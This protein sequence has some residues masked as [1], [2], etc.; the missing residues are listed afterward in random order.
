MHS[1]KEITMAMKMADIQKMVKETVF[2][3]IKEFYSESGEQFADF[4]IAVPITVE[5]IERWA[6]ISVVCGQ[7]KDTK[8]AKAFDPFEV[9]SEWQ[10]EKE[11]KRIEAE[12]KAKAKADREKAK[13]AKSKAKASD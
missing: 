1:R 3:Q 4:S 2:E 12:T 8:T 7:L 6:K 9:A 5:G 10:S 11:I 13:K